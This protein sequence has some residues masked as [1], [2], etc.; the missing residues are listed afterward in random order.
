LRVGAYT[1]ADVAH[2]T[3]VACLDGAGD[4]SRLN[5]AAGTT[6]YLQVL[7][8]G[9]SRKLMFSVDVAAAVDTTKPVIDSPPKA[10]PLADSVLSAA[11]TRIDWAGH[12]ADSG[13]DHYELQRKNGSGAWTTITTTGTTTFTVTE[14]LAVAHTFR[15][16]AVDVAG[17]IGDWSTGPAYTPTLKESTWA[18]VAYSG[19]WTTTS[20][21]G[22]SGTGVRKTTQLGATATFTFTGRGFQIVSIK[23]PGRGV[24]RVSVDGTLTTVD[25]SAASTM[26]QWIAF[27]R[28]FATS[29]THTIVIRNQGTAR[30]DLDAFVIYK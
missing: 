28:S 18:K 25:L 8:I 11:K 7:G 29:G 1:G 19:T 3:Q 17:N 5:V 6:Y 26:L 2:L 10:T 16:R 12:D 4:D 23:A 20:V 30:I 13:I 21:S 15:V 14:K 9:G 22:A 24:M 27:A